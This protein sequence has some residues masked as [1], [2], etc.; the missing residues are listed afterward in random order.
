MSVPSLS[1]TDKK[2][3]VSGTSVSFQVQLQANGGGYQVISNYT[4][5]GKTSGRYQR[6]L[7][8]PLTGNPPWDIRIV[9]TTADSTSQLLQNDLYWDT[10]AMLTDAQIRYRNSAIIGVAIDASQFSSIPS[11]TYEVLGM[12]IQVPTNYDPTSRT[13]SGV[14]NGTFKVAY[15][16]NPAWIFYDL[17]TNT[18]YGIGN[19]ISGAQIDKFALYSIAQW[20]DGLVPDGR[21]GYEPR[22]VCNAVIND[23]QEAFDLLQSMAS[24][25]RGAHYWTGGQ[26]VTIADKPTDPVGIYTNANVINGTFDYQGSDL[27]ARHTQVAVTWND[28]AN[29]GQPRVSLVDDQDAISRYGLNRLDLTGV[30]CTT[31]QQAIRIGKWALYTENNEL[32]TVKFSVGLDGAWCRPGDVIHVSD[33]LVAQE[34]RG[35]RLLAQTTSNTL[36]LD[37]PVVFNDNSLSYVSVI[38]GDGTIATVQVAIPSLGD[39]QLTL[40]PLSV[41]DPAPLAG[42]PWVLST[43]DLE[44]ALFRVV[45]V[46]QGDDDVTFAITALSHN[47]SKWAYVELGYPLA[48]RDVTNFAL[49]TITNLAVSETLVA[50]TTVSL[51][52]VVSLSWESKAPRF[53]VRWRKI[54]GIWVTANTIDMSFDLDAT[55]GVYEFLVTPLSAAGI[56]G[57]SAYIQHEVVG[58]TGAPNDV[59]NFR[60]QNINAMAHLTWAPATDADV[61]AGGVFELRFSPSTSSVGW[62]GAN[63]IVTAVPGNATT[64]EVPYRLGTYLIKAKDTSGIYSSNAALVITTQS[65][66]SYRTYQRICDNPD[67][68]GF[69]DGTM[70]QMPQEWIVLGESGGLWDEQLAN[71][72][73]WPAIDLLPLGVSGSTDTTGYYYFEDMLD[74][75]GVFPVILTA[76]ILAFPYVEGTTFIDDRPGDADSWQD[77]DAVGEDA[78]GMAVMELRQTDQDPADSGAIWTG[79]GGMIASQYEGRGFQFRLRLEAPAGQNIAVEQACVWIDFTAK[80]DSGADVVWTPNSQTITFTTQFFDTPAIAI[81]VQ[82]AVTGDYAQLSAKS[83]TG[84]TMVLRNSAGAVIVAART[85]DWQAQ[86]Y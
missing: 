55:L 64:V 37:H 4:I 23:R 20:C 28:P 24:V 25:F 42:S 65:A 75:G 34:R 7:T 66:T 13:Y 33:V 85:F 29:L 60:I 35:G 82:G 10:Y 56:R 6:S 49:P 78:N 50:I 47:P 51:L 70:K 83:N 1:S 76:D 19:F 46:E 16:N 45:S 5:S 69:K 52:I 48:N 9:R 38:K 22:W 11:R 61:L 36:Y 14:W 26:L 67:W 3:N 80:Q 68:L 74:I 41:I 62:G 57:K 39:D 18:R 53:E 81:A 72:D 73:T 71:L 15:S 43:G 32:E 27:R 30:G 77:W 63:V 40:A 79:W 54:D 58:L 12:I 21:G 2:G 8:F 17:V 84:F 86:G 44:T 59:K 31:E